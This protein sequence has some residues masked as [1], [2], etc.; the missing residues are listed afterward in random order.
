[1]R[2][3]DTWLIIFMIAIVIGLVY[4]MMRNNNQ[5]IK[6]TGSVGDSN[7]VDPA[8]PKQ[9]LVDKYNQWVD[10]YES[11][12]SDSGPVGVADQLKEEVGYSPISSDV[13][14]YMDNYSDV[15]GGSDASVCSDQ[16][17]EEFTYGKQKFVKKSQDKLMKEFDITALLPKETR[18][19]WFDVSHVK[20]PKKIDDPN[21]IHPTVLAGLQKARNPLRNT[22]RDIRGDIPVPKL[23]TLPWNNPSIDMDI[24][25]V[26]ICGQR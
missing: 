9:Q 26:G 11:D 7:L 2:G 3:S 17:D 24:E 1:M 22:S 21:M 25:N 23:T 8:S 15:T 10:R 5:P 4:Y 16:D 19:D 12:A 13:S 20:Q 14:D 6:N 18:P